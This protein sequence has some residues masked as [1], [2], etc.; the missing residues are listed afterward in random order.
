MNRWQRE[1]LLPIAAAAIVWGL[2]LLADG[3]RPY[4][5]AKESVLIEIPRGTGTRA[6]A[7]MLEETGVIRSRTTFLWLH[8]LWSR[9]TLKAGE[10]SFDQ[11]ASTLEILRKLLRGEIAYKVLVIPEGY[12]R[13]EVAAA[14]AAQGFCPEEECL[15]ATQDTSLIADL[16]PQAETLEGYLFPDTYHVPLRA[17]PEQLV[18]AMVERFRQVYSSLNPPS[19]NR[20]LHEIVTMASLAEKE[21]ALSEERPLVAAVFY[22]RLRRGIAL[23]CDPTV[24]YAA[25]LE[26]RYDGVIRQSHLS[27]R[28]PYNT[29][30][31]RGLPPG[32]ISSPG[33][34]SLVAAMHPAASDYLYFVADAEGQRHTFSRTLAEHN[35]AVRQYRRSQNP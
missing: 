13:F 4:W 20:S 16:A 26:N 1:M 5:H 14:M 34:D 31:H 18:G 15:Q 27:S 32:P 24:I 11:P 33:K 19:E 8:V 21:T 10:Y 7:Q 25:L 23:Q 35:T 28:S 6:I 12:N 22:N 3:T 9:G 29:Y 17:R 30:I 2:W